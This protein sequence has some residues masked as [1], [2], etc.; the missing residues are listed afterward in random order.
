MVFTKRLSQEVGVN[1]RLLG[2]FLLKCFEQ[3]N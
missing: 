2:G 3:K 1:S